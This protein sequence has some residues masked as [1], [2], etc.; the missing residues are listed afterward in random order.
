MY[1]AGNDPYDVKPDGD[2]IK[3]LENKFGADKVGSHE[4]P[5]MF[6]G[7]TTRGDISDEKVKRDVTEAINLCKDYFAKFE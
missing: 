3:I 7:W 2:V 1:P 5:E 4:F 6:H